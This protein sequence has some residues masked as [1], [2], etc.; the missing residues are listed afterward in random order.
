[1]IATPVA[2]LATMGWCVHKAGGSGNI[3]AQKA[4]V[5]GSTKAYL[6]LSSMSQLLALGPHSHATFQISP[7]MLDPVMGNSYNFP[8]FPSSSPYVLLLG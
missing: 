6:F 2:A 5:S 7:D 3:F 4:T 8:S 1:M